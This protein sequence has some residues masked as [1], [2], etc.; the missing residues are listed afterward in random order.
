MTKGGGGVEQML[1]LANKGG[2]GLANFEITEKCLKMAKNMYFYPT[3]PDIIINFVQKCTFF[4][5]KKLCRMRG[6]LN[7]FTKLTRKREGRLGKY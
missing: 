1:T 6:L 3:H 4:Q 2:W 5:K 7:M